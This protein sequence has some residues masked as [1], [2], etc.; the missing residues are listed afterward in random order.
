MKRGEQEMLRSVSELTGYSILATDG[1]IGKV[2]EF[3]FDDITWTIR[4]LVVDT[5]NWLVDQINMDFY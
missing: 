1:Q 4:Y 3:Y 2:A 5:G